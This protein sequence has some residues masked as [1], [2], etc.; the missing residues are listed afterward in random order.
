[1]Q[2]MTCAQTLVRHESSVTCLAISRGRLFSGSVDSSIKVST[3]KQVFASHNTKCSLPSPLQLLGVA[4]INLHINHT[5][6][7]IKSSAYEQLATFYLLVE[8]SAIV[9]YP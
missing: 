5:T 3:T 4:M 9:F 1:M 7:Y 2:H 8:I 6:T